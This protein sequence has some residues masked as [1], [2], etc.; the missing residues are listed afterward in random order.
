[1]LHWF[2]RFCVLCSVF[3]GAEGLR[4]AQRPLALSPSVFCFLCSV[5]CVLCS[6]GSGGSHSL[7]RE[8]N[9]PSAPSAPSGGSRQV[10]RKPVSAC[11]AP[12]NGRTHCAD[13]PPRAADQDAR[14]DT[15]ATPIGQRTPRQP[16]THRS[17]SSD[18][19]VTR[20]Q[21]QPHAHHARTPRTPPGL[22]HSA[23]RAAPTGARAARNGGG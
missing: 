13:S 3:C 1:M 21:P 22:C 16:P 17:A 20:G 15:R 23:Q 14:I 18:A 11:Y 6:G 12:Y 5:F 4:G 10:R 9:A 8:H 7:S 19:R 2:S